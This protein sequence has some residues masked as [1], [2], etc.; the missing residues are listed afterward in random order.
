MEQFKLMSNQDS[1]E[2]LNTEEDQVPQ[3]RKRA[4]NDIKDIRSFKHLD[5]VTL[6]LDSPR[7]LQAC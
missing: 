7:F 3:K 6:E 2:R 1:K 4:I 5:R